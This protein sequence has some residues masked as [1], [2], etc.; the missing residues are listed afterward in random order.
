MAIAASFEAMNTLKYSSRQYRVIALAA[1]AHIAWMVNALARQGRCDEQMFDW[2]AARLFESEVS[3]EDWLHAVCLRTL[4]QQL[5]GEFDAHAKTIMHYMMG[6][7]TLEKRLS[8]QSEMLRM[9]AERL[10]YISE[11]KN[12]FGQELHENTIAAIASLYG[13]SISTLKPRIIIHGKPEYLNHKSNTNRLR[14]LLLVG[15]RAAHMWRQH[16][17][18]HFRLIVERKKMLETLNDLQHRAIAGGGSH[19]HN[20]PD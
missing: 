9:L 6:L 11:N 10:H 13:E 3:A 7:L 15:I 20:N 18:N 5:R 14:T 4:R 2:L 19:G 12:F 17:G 8:Q 16:G 1:L